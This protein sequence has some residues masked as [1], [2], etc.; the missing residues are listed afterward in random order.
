MAEATDRPQV[1][2]DA[3]MPTE[4]LGASA[5]VSSETY[6]PLSLF[7]MASFG[8]SVVYALVVLIGAAVALVSHIPW[9]MP[10][11]TFLIPIAVLVVCWAARTRI[12]NSEGTMSGLGFTT[13]GS[14]LAILCSVPYAAY[15]F[16][17]FLA[18]RSP[19]IDRANDFLQKIKESRLDLAFLQS[20]DISIKGK[21]KNLLRDEIETR[22]NQPAGTVMVQPGT[23]STF[24]QQHFVRY[25]E[26][27]GEK[28]ITTPTGV[29]S[30]EFGKGGYR[31]VL[32][33][34]VATSL[35]EFDFK[36]DTFGRDPKPGEPKSRQWQV[37]LARSETGIVTGSLRYTD[38]GQDFVKKMTNAQKFAMEWASRVSD[39]DTL[40][41]E[42]RESYSKLI[43]GLDTFWASKLMRDEITQYVRKMF[44]AGKKFSINFQ[45]ND[46][47]FMRETDG[48]T[49]GAFDLMIRFT[50]ESS[51][52][53][54]YICEGRLLVSADS[55]AARDSSSAWRVDALEIDSGRTAPER[56]RMQKNMPIPPGPERAPGPPQQP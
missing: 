8:L 2:R 47:P 12:L 10:Y 54:L 27:D 45:P 52:M 34:H 37:Q 55:N 44:S 15:Y 9:L 39:V 56:R 22:F 1:P 24:C 3:V 50:E 26:M 5:P 42:E 48:R 7:A 38:K 49:T 16:A 14:R 51:P 36:I 17:T 41:P 20:Q 32:N 11:W 31:V 30:W 43:R 21:D 25:I 35:V 46:I 40:K 6:Q 23:F 18:V 29:D 13:W 4:A 53:P 19:A 33:Y 28:A